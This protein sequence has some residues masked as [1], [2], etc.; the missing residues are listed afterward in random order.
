MNTKFKNEYRRF[1][2]KGFGN[3][4]HET[5]FAAVVEAVEFTAIQRGVGRWDG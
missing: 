1:T 2:G 3:D 5:L 4:W